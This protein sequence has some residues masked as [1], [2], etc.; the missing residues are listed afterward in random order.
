MKEGN[1][2]PTFAA[3][4]AGVLRWVVLIPVSLLGCALASV[5]SYLFALLGVYMF[6]YGR[7]GWAFFLGYLFGGQTGAELTLLESAYVNGMQG[8][9]TGATL[10]YISA[11]IAPSHKIL[12]AYVFTGV[13]ILISGALVIHNFTIHKPSWLWSYA[14]VGIGAGIVAYL[15]HTG[16]VSFDK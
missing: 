10:V 11:R 14:C 13:A 1:D 15:V 8:G 9:L 12:V 4:I 5:L 2:H 3:R 16:K 6:K 7:L